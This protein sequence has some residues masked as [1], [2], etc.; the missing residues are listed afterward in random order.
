MGANEAGEYPLSA[1]HHCY[2]IPI[3]IGGVLS[4]CLRCAHN[5]L[6]YTSTLT[7]RG[8]TL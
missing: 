1:P 3:I 7:Y 5:L 6:R 4:I 2:V 8:L